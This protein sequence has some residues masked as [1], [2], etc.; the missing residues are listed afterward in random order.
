VSNSERNDVLPSGR[1]Q[2]VIHTCGKLS[3]EVEDILGIFSETRVFIEQ[4]RFDVL[5]V[6]ELACG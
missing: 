5:T 1:F 3:Q 6:G 4:L 2:Q